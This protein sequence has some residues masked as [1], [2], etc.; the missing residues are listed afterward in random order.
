[1]GGAGG[2]RFL[3]VTVTVTVLGSGSGSVIIH[4]FTTLLYSTLI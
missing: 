2:Y 4:N 1:M 3:W